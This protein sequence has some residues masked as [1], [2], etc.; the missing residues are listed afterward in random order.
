MD[1]VSKPLDIGEAVEWFHATVA[2]GDVDAALDATIDVC[3]IAT[4]LPNISQRV[5]E[6]LDSARA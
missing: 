5:R 1:V 6:I 2:L 4:G 3:C